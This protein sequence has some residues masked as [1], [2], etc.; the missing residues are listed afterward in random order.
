MK[1]NINRVVIMD[2]PKDNPRPE[3]KILY[4]NKG[5]IFNSYNTNIVLIKDNQVYLD[6]SY[7]NY[8]KTT[9]TYRNIFIEE[10]IIETKNKITQ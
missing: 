2:S 1:Y 7:W 9:G 3:Q 8:S 5:V 4:T 6:E 10:S